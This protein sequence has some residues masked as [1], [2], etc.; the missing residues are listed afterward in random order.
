MTCAQWYSDT[1][2]VKY[3]DGQPYF[4]YDSFQKDN[5]G[6]VLFRY[7]INRVDK[8]TPDFCNT[9]PQNHSV[10]G[11][12]WLH[13]LYFKLAYKL[14]Y[15]RIPV[16]SMLFSTGF[17]FW[18]VLIFTFYFLY[19]KN[20]GALF[21]VSFIIGLWLTMILGPLALYRYTFP[22]MVSIPILFSYAFGRKEFD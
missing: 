11:F 21:P 19:K 18:L 14:P 16:V 4:Q 15:E 8:I 10:F 1:F 12:Q 5:E 20:Y 22:L 6:Y 7:T 13:D 3:C 9:V 17:I 2:F